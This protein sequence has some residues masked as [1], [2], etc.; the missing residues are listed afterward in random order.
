[1]KFFKAKP[2]KCSICGLSEPEIKIKH[3]VRHTLGLLKYCEACYAKTYSAA[4]PKV[5]AQLNQ[6]KH[7][8]KKIELT[9]AKKITQEITQ[10]ITSENKM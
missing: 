4:L 2:K 3:Q 7:D 9:D 6:A 5:M 10:E 1:M 8:G